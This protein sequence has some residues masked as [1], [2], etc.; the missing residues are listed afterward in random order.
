ML[1]LKFGQR[2]TRHL[3]DQTHE[4]DK[5]KKWHEQDEKRRETAIDKIYD[6]AIEDIEVGQLLKRKG[7][8]LAKEIL[9]WRLNRV[10]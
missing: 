7:K 5:S 2:I 8:L 9:A 3:Y 10:D 6:R 4:I 1:K